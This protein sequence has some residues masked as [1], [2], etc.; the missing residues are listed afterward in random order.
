MDCAL[1]ENHT[2]LAK[3]AALYPPPPES[4]KATDAASHGRKEGKRT[5]EGSGAKIEGVSRIGGEFALAPEPPWLSKRLAILE[6]IKERNAKQLIELKKPAITVKLPDGKEMPGV[7]W[8]TSPLDI[9]AAIAKGLAN[10]TCVASVRYSS[11]H[12]GI[13]PA[14]VNADREEA[15]DMNGGSAE[16]ELWDAFRPLEGDCD[17]KLH[18]FDEPQ[19]KEV[20]WHSSAHI[21]GEALESLFSAQLT[22]GPALET[23]FFYDSYLGNNAFA[24]EM[25]GDVEKKVLK[26]I[27]EKKDFERVVITKE[28]ALSLFADN[29]FKMSII[30]SKIPDNAST[31]VYRSGT[32]VDLCRGPHLPNTGRIKA[33]EVT[34]TS[35]SLWLGKQGNDQ[36]QRVYGITFPDKNQHKEWKHF[37]EEAAK[38]DHRKI[39]IEQELF[40]FDEMSP[41]S[42]FFLPLGGRIYNKLCS[43]IREQLWMRGYDEVVTP[44]MYNMNLWH[45]SGHAAKYKDNMFCLD[46]EQQEFGLKPMNCPGHCLMFKQR[47]RSYRELPLRLADFG[48]LHRNEISGALT[49]LTRVRRFQQDDAHIFCMVSQIKEEVTG[50]LDMIKTVYDWLGMDFALKLSTKPETALGDPK[51]WEIAE[52]YMAEALDLFK[53]QVGKTWSLNPGDGAFYGPKIDVQVFDALKRPHQCA[54]VQLDFVQPMRFNLKYQSAGDAKH[55]NDGSGL[56]SGFERP[57]MVHRAVLGSVERMIAILT[58]HFAGKWPVWLSPRQ[59]QVV[60]VSKIYCDYATQVQRRL[61]AEGFYADVDLS[62]RTLKKM[63]RESQLAQYNFILVVGADESAAESVN[64]RSRDNEV[65]GMKTLHAFIDELHGLVRDKK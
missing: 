58:E 7:A 11:R 35:A 61:R 62:C 41:G 43:V 60:P 32:F 6:K 37:Q 25:E 1:F 38:R 4:A 34:K 51:V 3:L 48:V 17:L 33:F 19:G 21:L 5:T 64:V 56:E 22:H 30:T 28:D 40:F 39:G 47:N 18:K 44:N 26:I 20:F 59:C 42:C 10:A 9:A 29:P 52:R 14:V 23:G 36:L 55:E 65:L 53:D 45:T 8:Q 27:G 2:A 57:V 50:C 54:T 46:I 31:T 12:A 15:D 16:W 63:I 13:G 24:K 49:G